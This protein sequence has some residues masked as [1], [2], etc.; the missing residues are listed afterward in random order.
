MTSFYYFTCLPRREHISGDTAR[1]SY[2]YSYGY[3]LGLPYI[4]Q[5]WTKRLIG[6]AEEAG[7]NGTQLVE[8]IFVNNPRECF[9][10]KK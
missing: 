6:E 1:K 5:E 9:T 4:K 3:A 8:D 10:F 7:I 2:Y